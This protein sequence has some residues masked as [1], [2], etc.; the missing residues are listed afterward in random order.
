M[1]LLLTLGSLLA[2]CTP[3]PL[4]LGAGT[5]LGWFWCYVVPVRCALAR[6]QVRATLGVGAREAGRIVRS[7][8]VET[9]RNTLE[10]M[11]WRRFLHVRKGV[12]WYGIEG[13]GN[14]EGA[15]AR[16]RGILLLTGHIGNFDLV[17]CCE[18]R[19]GLPVH[20]LS[21]RLKSG[22]AN[23][24]WMATRALLGV[25]ILPDD[26][27]LA[28]ALEALRRNE[29]VALVLDQH[30]REERAVESPFLGTPARTS[31]ALATLAVRSGAAIVPCFIHRKPDGTHLVEYLPPVEPA[32]D[33]GARARIEATTRLC[34]AVLER[35]IRKHPGQWLWMHRRWKDRD[36][37]SLVPLPS[38]RAS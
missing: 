12:P 19:R 24:W 32:R 37:R 11:A 22:G 2:A 7:A 5:C 18:A 31:S 38:S 1:R 33:G 21:K 20:I 23:A 16:G 13:L 15:F 25:R 17:A 34:L 8:C 28:P 35:Q 9:A 4:L 30:S 3:R 36:G 26:A 27:P 10:L 14:L 6:A 29:V